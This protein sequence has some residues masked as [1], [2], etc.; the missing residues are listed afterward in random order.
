[1]HEI[2]QIMAVIDP[3][4]DTQPAMHRAAWLAQHTGADLELFV[5]YYNE[6]LRAAIDSSTRHRSRKRGRRSS[7]V[8]RSTSRNLRRRYGNRVSR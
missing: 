2:K 8:T 7:P 1:M 3:T 4:T 5:C 6:Y